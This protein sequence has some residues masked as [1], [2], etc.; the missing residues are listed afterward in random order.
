MRKEKATSGTFIKRKETDNE[1]SRYNRASSG[2][3]QESAIGLWEQ[4]SGLDEIWAG[5][6]EKTVLKKL[7]EK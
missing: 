3:G 6:E 1:N 4:F 7:E 2:M 5:E